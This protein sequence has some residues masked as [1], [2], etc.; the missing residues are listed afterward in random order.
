MNKVALIS[1]LDDIKKTIYSIDY[2][3]K[4]EIVEI[5]LKLD[6]LKDEI[7]NGSKREDK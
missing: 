6:K 3:K 7:I 2:S 1:K 4:E 5:E